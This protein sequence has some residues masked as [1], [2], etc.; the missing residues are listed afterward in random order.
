M[1]RDHL[2]AGLSESASQ[3]GANLIV[4]SRVSKIDDST[5][6]GRVIVT[7]D[8]NKTYIFDLVIG[9]DGIRSVVRQH[10]FPGVMPKAPSKIAAY[11]GVLSYEQVL[12]AV[13]EA[14]NLL[15]NTMD[16]WD[17]AK[18]Y[19]LTYPISGG[20]ELNVVTAFTKDDYVTKMEKVTMDEFR[21]YYTDYNPVIQK[22]LELVD[23]TQRWPL[24]QMP[25]MKRWSNEKR[26]VV[27]LGD[28]AHC[29]QNHM[30]Q[31]AATA[32]EDG[33]FIGRIIS[34]VVRGVIEIPEAVALY[35]ERRIPKAWIKQQISFTSGLINTAE[36][37]EREE[38]DQASMPEV[39]SFS[40]NAVR[41]NQL[42]PTYRSWQYYSNPDSI[43]S[44]FYYDAEADADNAV[45]EYLQKSGEVDERSMLSNNLKQKWMGVLQDNGIDADA[46]KNG[47]VAR[48]G[49]KEEDYQRYG[50]GL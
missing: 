1:R 11:R 31:G 39:Q 24:L 36:E 17:S 50:K 5:D 19:I 28:A 16:V 37:Q 20:K 3:H 41:P 33:A 25:P 38:R 18:G 12:K 49:L 27:L 34:E 14:R 23:Y 44:V 26:N 6:P 43:P 32:M 8:A 47:A 9:A 29:M 22:V 21:G 13:P 35:E 7:T 30:A 2:H 45:L 46:V 10:F 4:N 48:G 42:P 40:A 15:R